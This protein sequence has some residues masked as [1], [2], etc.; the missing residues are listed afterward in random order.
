MNRRRESAP[1]AGIH[2]NP[3]RANTPVSRPPS[4]NTGHRSISPSDDIVFETHTDGKQSETKIYSSREATPQ[5]TLGYG[6]MGTIGTPVSETSPLLN[7][8]CHTP[9]TDSMSEEEDQPPFFSRE[10][11]AKN[12]WTLLKH[13]KVFILTVAAIVSIVFIVINPEHEE[14]WNQVSVQSNVDSEIVLEDVPSGVKGRRVLLTFKGPFGNPNETN[15]N[16]DLLSV[17]QGMKAVLNLSVNM[18]A[19]SNHSISTVLRELEL[20]DLKTSE[21]KVNLKF[22]YNPVSINAETCLPVEYSYTFTAD[23]KSEEVCAL[24]VLILVYGLIIF[25][26]VHRTLA[27]ILGSLATVAVMSAFGLRPT[28]EKIMTWLDVET[29]SLLFGMMIIV[30]IFSETG[31]FDYC[32][33]MA[34]KL[35]KGQVW[36]LITLLCAFSA[37]VSAFLDNVTTILLLTPVTIRLCEVLNLDPKKILIAE[38]LFSN[39][40]GTATAIGDPPNV[41]I[42]SHKDVKANKIEFSNFTAH[43]VVG[44]VFCSF[45]GYGLLRLFYRNMEDLENKDPIEITELRHEIDMW[46][47]AAKRIVAISREEKVMQAIFLQRVAELENKLVKQIYKMKRRKQKNFKEM[48]AE[49]EKK[50][51]ITDKALLVKSG[52]VLAVVILL[53]FLH[54]FIDE[55]HIGLGWIAIMGA[56]MLMVLADMQDLETILHMVEWSTLIFFAALFSLMEGLK[57]LGLISWIGGGVKSILVDVE[58]DQQILVAIILILW[59]S[60]IASSF[61]DNIPFTT[62][63]IPILITVNEDVGIPLMPMILALAFGACLGGNGTLIGASANVVSAGIAEQHGYG[64]SFLDFFR[65]GFPMMLVTTFVAMGYLLISHAWGTWGNDTG[66]TV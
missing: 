30:A 59:V 49:L 47:R 5:S 45:A 39:I 48:L 43:M 13:L 9:L 36:P 42:V 6:T 64:F 23:T 65:V 38:V 50:H 61:I 17:T 63:M 28:L 16:S 52:I 8:V 40:G 55:M 10:N 20:N 22:D 54:S 18:V 35:A 37:V 57:E 53:F 15:D 46:K 4:L 25:D 32:A 31:F 41:I 12:K 2:V 11:F 19:L 34:Y 58:K 26:L 66:A 51:K 14:T 7:E 60:A 24:I 27:A 62:A 21:D 33:L 44:I 56:I 29:L 1:E 3:N